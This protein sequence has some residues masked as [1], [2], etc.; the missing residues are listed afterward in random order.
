M[1][2]N[3]RRIT[4]NGPLINFNLLDV[5]QTAAI[6]GFRSHGTAVL[7]SGDQLIKFLGFVFTHAHRATGH[8]HKPNEL[9]KELVNP[10][11]ED[12]LAA[13]KCDEFGR[14]VAERR[15]FFRYEPKRG[16]VMAAAI[17]T[18][19][20]ELTAKF[21]F[22]RWQSGFLF[23]KPGTVLERLRAYKRRQGQD[24]AISQSDLR[25]QMQSRPYWVPPVKVSHYKRFGGSRSNSVCWCIDLDEHEQGLLSVPDDQFEGAL[26]MANGLPV[27]SAEWVDPRRGKLF[28]LIDSLKN[29][30]GLSHL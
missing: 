6:L 12:V 11:W 5:E 29:K 26:K 17:S 4:V 1:N 7:V 22:A 23:F 25:V 21:P 14:T 19:Q 15:H 20:Q 28:T 13:L 10:F 2:N 9:V 8:V 24:L 3:N 30:E 27:S 18:R 16:E